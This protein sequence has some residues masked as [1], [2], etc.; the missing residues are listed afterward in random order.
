M[1]QEELNE[2][3]VLDAVIE[4]LAATSPELESELRSLLNTAAALSY[5]E[6]VL[7]VSVNLKQRLFN[8][9]QQENEV[10][11]FVKLKGT[12]LKWKPHPVKGLEMAVLKIDRSK[13][14]L[15][16]LVRAD[17]TVKYP[18]HR[19]EVGEEIF[20]IKG[21]LIDRGLTCKAGDYI[22]SEA[23]SVHSS[24]ALAGCMFFI[25]TS[26]EDTFL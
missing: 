13:K 24:T 21:E 11:D 22:H 19:H 20:M 16:A 12:N 2:L 4:E 10:L 17:I 26:L 14:E 23:G 7:E 6:N 15:S 18:L 3:S 8:R 5:S 25:R 9:I 1:K